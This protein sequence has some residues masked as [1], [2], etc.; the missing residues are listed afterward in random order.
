VSLF[1]VIDTLSPEAGVPFQVSCMAEDAA[2]NLTEL[3]SA[4]VSVRR[5]RSSHQFQRDGNV[6]TLLTVATFEMVCQVDGLQSE[7]LA[8]RPRPGLASAWRTGLQGGGGTPHRISIGGWTVPWHEFLD[9]WGNVTS[10]GTDRFEVRWSISPDVPLRED[11]S[12]QFLEEGSYVATATWLDNSSVR[13]SRDIAIVVTGVPPLLTC[14]NP[15]HLSSITAAAGTEIALV[16]TAFDDVGV[17]QVTVNGQVA[18]LDSEGVWEIRHIVQPGINLL[19]VR[20]AAFDLGGTGFPDRSALVCAFIASSSYVDGDSTLTGAVRLRLGREALDDGAPGVPPRSVADLLSN[21]LAP[22]TIAPLIDDQ[23]DASSRLWS[24]CIVPNPFG[25]CLN[26]GTLTYL[27]PFTNRGPNRV[28][29]SVA[30]SRLR[31]TVTI[32]DVTVPTRLVVTGLP[33]TTVTLRVSTLTVGAEYTLSITSGGILRA[34]QNRIVRTTVGDLSATFSP[35][36]SLYSLAFDLAEATIRTELQDAM[37][38]AFAEIGADVLNDA[39]GSFALTAIGGFLESPPFL[40]GD[41]VLSRLTLQP[42]AVSLLN[43]GIDLR[44]DGSITSLD[45]NEDVHPPGELARLNASSPVM[46]DNGFAVYLNLDL[47]N[48]GLARLWRAGYFDVELA[49]LT[50]PVFSGTSTEYLKVDLIADIAPMLSV[51]DGQ[52]WLSMAGLRTT[53]FE[54]LLAFTGLTTDARIGAEFR[55]AVEGDGQGGFALTGLELV[56]IISSV[57]PIQYSTGEIDAVSGFLV[58]QVDLFGTI[59]GLADLVSLPLPAIVGSTAT[60]PL[61]LQPGQSFG[62]TNTTVSFPTHFLRVAGSLGVIQ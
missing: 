9:A 46:T 53:I 60:V 39:L 51:R 3:E 5:S 29:L 47:F 13:D 7:G 4:E 52:L 48:Q 2:G 17:A 37:D 30:S 33:N 12:W 49:D 21:A 11:R 10:R 22:A 20:A 50:V 23:L 6:V 32:N 15:T 34:T 56:R 40:D 38:G 41:P 57:S 58:G 26:S 24:G 45:P 61:G 18:D 1:A 35:T 27:G 59:G 62:L 43:S 54:R 44:F 14:D 42:N 31:F 28:S 16:G 36:N 19:D 8:V 25:G 55:V